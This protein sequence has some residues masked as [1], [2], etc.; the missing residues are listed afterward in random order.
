MA[1]PQPPPEPDA[2]ALRVEVDRLAGL[3]L[4][5]YAAERRA[6]AHKQGV[7][8]GDLERAVR[9][10]RQ[11]RAAAARAAQAATS[12][13]PSVLTEMH[14]ADAFVEAYAQRFYRWVQVWRRWHVW[15][16]R[17]WAP[18]RTVHVFDAVRQHAKRWAEIGVHDRDRAMLG[19]RTTVAAVEA[20][21]RGYPD[22]SMVPEQWDVAPWL[23]N[24]PGGVVDLRTGATAPHD[25]TLYMSKLTRGSVTAEPWWESAPRW[26]MFLHEMTGGNTDV[27]S[28]LQ[29]FAG[30]ACTGSAREHALAFM[31][32]SGGN[33]KGTFA[34]A[35]EHALGDYA[36]A[37]PEG[38]L[39][40]Q[41]GGDR[42][43]TELSDL[44]GM[45]FAFAS[46]T[47]AGSRWNEVRLKTLTGGDRVRARSMHRDFFEFAPSHTL[48]VLGNHPPQLRS[49][50]QAI[51]RRLQVVPLTHT[52]A[53][54]DL[55]LPDVLAAEADGVLS[56]AVEG[57]RAWLEYGLCPPETVT[58]A[59]ESYFDAQDPIAEWIE[60]SCTT[61]RTSCAS[62]RDLYQSY[63]SFVDGR[64]ETVLS[65]RRFGDEL[66]KRGFAR[67]KVTGGRRV[68]RGIDVVWE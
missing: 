51:R 29:R 62:P 68:H 4:T 64:G 41:R 58:A 32:G 19:S 49:V 53:E 33:G 38:F 45:R 47:E 2:S 13:A 39:A 17:V 23:L 48:L 1:S 63:A 24:T 52:A 42:H 59:S 60:S 46:E 66:E 31:Y 34:N 27:Q 61:S 9:E 50:D 22:I 3:D 16:G 14:L 5:D 55:E 30:Y 8:L 35:L 10:A 18:D 21:A 25:A 26:R 15:D 37:L 44:H 54:I 7:S 67:A 6:A 40:E 43:P 11:R 57:A 65:A 56:W 20:L 12:N 28:Y 36:I